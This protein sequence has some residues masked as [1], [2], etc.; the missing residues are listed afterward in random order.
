MAK[1]ISVAFVA[2]VAAMMVLATSASGNGV[3]GPYTFDSAHQSATF[4]DANGTWNG[5]ITFTT[6]NPMAWSFKLAPKLVGI[7]TGPMTCVMNG[8][9]NGASTGYHDTHVIPAS[10]TWHSTVPQTLV[11]F[12]YQLSGSCTFRVKGGTANLGIVFNYNAQ[13]IN[14]SVVHAA[15]RPSF[16]S[17]LS[18]SSAAPAYGSTL[19][20][21]TASDSL[22]G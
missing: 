1:R 6:E 7:A 4:S 18:I 21:T 11:G 22:G 3:Y 5:Q 20:I 14:D 9:R 13:Y 15:A 19:T 10:Y 17:S 2:I 16:S 12:N 8:Y